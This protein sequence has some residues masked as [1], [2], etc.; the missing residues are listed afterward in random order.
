MYYS[1][2]RS[3]LR[4]PGSADIICFIFLSLFYPSNPLI[5][6]QAK[7]SQIKPGFYRKSYQEE[8]TVTSRAVRTCSISE[9]LKEKMEIIGRKNKDELE[10]VEEGGF[11]EISNQSHRRHSVTEWS[12]ESN[13]EA[14]S[15]T[16]SEW[17]FD[18]KRRPSNRSS[19]TLTYSMS[20]EPE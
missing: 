20:M 16:T 17:Y 10:P 2:A 9:E 13:A 8:P 7:P 1:L 18:G 12:E 6:C 3:P 14:V 5:N 11:E 4:L 15:K 19:A